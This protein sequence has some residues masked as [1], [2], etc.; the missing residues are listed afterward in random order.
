[1]IG[2]P[3]Y[4]VSIKGDYRDSVT[5]ALGK[6]P[7]FEIY[8]YF[9]LLSQKLLRSD[10]ILSF[11]IP[12]TWL[13]NTFAKDWRKS[14]FFSWNIKQILDCSQFNIFTEPTVRNSI[15]V[16]KKSLTESEFITYKNTNGISSFLDL[17]N[18][19]DSTLSKANLLEMNQ[20]W[21]LAFKLAPEVV[22]II[23]KLVN[24]KFRISDFYDCSQ[25]Y[26]PYRLSDLIKEF[27]EKKGTEIK[28][29]RLWH[30]PQKSKEYFIQE[31][32]GRD[33]TKY[34]VTPN[35]EYVKYGK[36][37]ASYVDLKFFT[38]P[39]LL[40]REITNPSIIAG[41]TEDTYINDPQ[42]L[43]IINKSKKANLK[44][45]WAIMNSR[46]AT[47]YHFNH[48]PKATKGAFPKILVQDLKDFPLPSD[49]L[50]D[51]RIITLVDK[52]LSIKKAT[53]DVNTS[54]LEK[55]LDEYIYDLYCLTETE[56]TIVRGK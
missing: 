32:F 11:I 52:I 46:L 12:N 22:S 8:Y 30:S 54:E 19:E 25:G 41:Y 6:V 49:N 14:L 3:P 56:K 53:P 13:F 21:G 26:I 10:G 24:Q 7:D 36:H 48:S 38:S 15:I 51:S 42:I 29:K 16:F 17:I 18:Q 45:L 20:N 44:Y 1:M 9:T 40:V 47:F 37:C 5:K 50:S 27:G 39:R 31:I 34:S 2:N 28:E 55:Q 4:G 33:M 23:N 35:G 43:L